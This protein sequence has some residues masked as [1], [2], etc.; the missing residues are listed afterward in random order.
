MT[1]YISLPIAGRCESSQRLKAKMFQRYFENEG[2]FVVNPFDLAD[3]LNRCF[4]KIG[5]K[6]TYEDYMEADLFNLDFCSH[7]FLCEGWHD[8]KGCIREVE[9]ALEGDTEFLYESTY[10]FG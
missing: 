5:Q 3:H 6:P 8:S 10:K 4:E 1:I 9:K 2:H 7:V